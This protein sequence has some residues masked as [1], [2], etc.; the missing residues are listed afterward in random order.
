MYFQ[1]RGNRYSFIYYDSKRK[2]NS[3]LPLAET[4]HIT[5]ELEA[6]EFCRNWN[7][8]HKSESVQVEE[9]MRWLTDYPEFGPLIETYIKARQEDAKN[10]WQSSL[11]LLKYYAF[12]F[13]LNFK[14][15]PNLDQW[16]LHFEE[17][18]DY[19]KQAESIKTM[20]EDR[21]IS[22]STKNGAI[23][24]LNNFLLTMFRRNKIAD[25]NKC[26]LFPKSVLNAKGEESVMGSE[27]REKIYEA[28]QNRS[29]LSADMFY[30]GLHTG[31][32]LNELVGLSLADVFSGFP[33]GETLKKALEPHGMR[34]YGFISL[35]DQPALNPH[36]RNDEFDVPRKPLKGKS[37]I[38]ASHSRTIPI[39][40][41]HC[42]NTL[43]KLWNIQQDLF[44]SR[45]FGANPKNYLLF[46]DLTSDGF[47][48]ELLAAQ[49]DLPSFGLRYYTPH[50]TRHTYCTWLAEKTGGDFNL[51][52]MIL[53]HSSFEITL[54]YVH[55]AARINRQ[56]S[57]IRQLNSPMAL[58]NAELKST[59]VTPDQYGLKFGYHR[60][61]NLR[62]IK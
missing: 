57:N 30:V 39:F 41:V 42:F 53:G 55:M 7:E 15:E 3:R 33:E 35:E 13:F 59:L 16:K 14:K 24:A 46:D 2:S 12:D 8:T 51:C 9:R 6:E 43:A 49:K 61:N 60:R 22:Y 56:L 62:S 21:L 19:L 52:K 1:R 34:V 38:S 18:R 28:L 54:H 45:V 26:R 11:Y 32:R 25:L 58:I 50:D 20:K 29:P 44:A 40:D 10:S 17:F 23:K 47:Y 5:S 27:A 36:P 48:K 31:M 37:K 4:S